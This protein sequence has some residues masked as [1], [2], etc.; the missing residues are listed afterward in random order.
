MTLTIEPL[1]RCAQCIATLAEWHDREWRH[2]NVPEYDLS[3]R[4]R[5]YELALQDETLPQMFVALLDA[6]VVG[7]VRIIHNNM[8]NH[9]QWFPWLASLYVYPPYRQRGIATQLIARVIEETPRL[10]YC[11]LYLL[12]EDQQSMYQ[13]LGW[14]IVCEEEY[15]GQIVSIM[16]RA[17][18]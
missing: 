17:L 1:S 15:N 9:P 3:A 18:N 2:L 14:R 4:I 16:H 6:T 12:T 5:D 8:D 7:S 11:Q 10:G 13:R